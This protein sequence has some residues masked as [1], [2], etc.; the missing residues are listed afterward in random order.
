LKTV[1]LFK[2]FIRN[3]DEAAASYLTEVDPKKIKTKILLLKKQKKIIKSSFK[4][5]ES[6]RTVE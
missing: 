3:A 5:G 1:L 6:Q 2:C 4:K